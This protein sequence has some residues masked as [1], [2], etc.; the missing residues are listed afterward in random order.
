MRLSEKLAP[1]T[2]G[3]ALF[4]RSE[5]RNCFRHGGMRQVDVIHPPRG[6]VR[7][8]GFPFTESKEHQF[9]TEAASLAAANVPRVIPP[10]GLVV[11]MFEVIARELI[12]RSGQRLPIRKFA[13]FPQQ[14]AQQANQDSQPTILPLP[15]YDE[16]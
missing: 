6:W 9:K 15:C 8:A 10:F 13:G 11:R 4:S 7:F 1:A 16:S 5:Y 3:P 12:M 2:P 14:Y